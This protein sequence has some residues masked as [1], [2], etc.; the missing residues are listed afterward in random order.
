MRENEYLWSLVKV[1]ILEIKIVITFF[2]WVDFLRSWRDIQKWMRVFKRSKWLFMIEVGLFKVLVLVKLFDNH[3][4]AFY[5]SPSH[6]DCAF[7]FFRFTLS[8]FIFHLWSISL[9]QK[10]NQ[11]FS[12]DLVDLFFIFF[13]VHFLILWSPSLFH[14][15]RS[16]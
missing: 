5:W 9:Y 7:L 4:R 13:H 10:Q 1:V 2:D 14:Q 8:T 15:S 12:I 3:N 6:F 11:T 16:R